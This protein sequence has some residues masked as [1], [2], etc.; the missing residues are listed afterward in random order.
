M[1]DQKVGKRA[2]SKETRV[3]VW[4]GEESIKNG[5]RG[6]RNEKKRVT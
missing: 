5:T 2:P 6:K 4:G 1:K 3:K